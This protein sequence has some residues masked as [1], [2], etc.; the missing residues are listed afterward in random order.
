MKD[1]LH[2]LKDFGIWRARPTAPVQCPCPRGGLAC[3]AIRK[4]R[5]IQ[6]RLQPLCLKGYPLFGVANLL[7]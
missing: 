1:S 5:G 3:E 7:I 6:K 4:G 2:K